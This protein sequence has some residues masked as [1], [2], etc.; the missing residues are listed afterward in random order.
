MLILYRFFTYISCLPD[1]TINSETKVYIEFREGHKIWRNLPLSFDVKAG[2]F[3]KIILSILWQTKKL[4]NFEKL[5]LFYAK[6]GHKPILPSAKKF[7]LYKCKF[8]YSRIEVKQNCSTF[9]V[10]QFLWPEKIWKDWDNFFCRK[11]QHKQWQNYAEDL[12]KF[13]WP[14]Q[15]TSTFPNPEFSQKNLVT[16]ARVPIYFP[17]WVWK[18]LFVTCFFAKKHFQQIKTHDEFLEK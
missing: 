12:F 16:K 18:S 11:I 6:I 1:P 8:Y 2:L 15:K 5:W 3:F 10:C 17:G 7:F 9:F 13:L 4:S 14:S